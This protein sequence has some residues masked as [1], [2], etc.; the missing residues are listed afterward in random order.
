MCVRIPIS[1]IPF[2]DSLKVYNSEIQIPNFH[3]AT[4]MHL[5]L[6]KVA[7][8]ALTGIFAVVVNISVAIAAVYIVVDI[9]VAAVV[10]IVAVDI[11]VAA[12]YCCRCRCAF[13]CQQQSSKCAPTFHFCAPNTLN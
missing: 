11:I 13:D 1:T 12:C 8:N 10:V 6:T 9:I 5:L 2:I 4:L 7:S 3:F